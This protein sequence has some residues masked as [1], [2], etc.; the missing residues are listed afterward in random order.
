MPNPIT[1]FEIL[2]QNPNRLRQFY[3]DVFEWKI[4][5]NNEM[6]YG[7]LEAQEEKGIGGGVGFGEGGV[8]WAIPYIEVENVEAMLD[9]IGQYGGEVVIPS[10]TIPGMVTFGVFTDPEGNKLGVFSPIGQ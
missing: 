1:W 4:E 7:M 8:T 5:V 9:K 2:G 3:S 10:T 6:N